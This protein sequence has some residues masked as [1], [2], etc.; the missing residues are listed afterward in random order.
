MK[1][2]FDNLLKILRERCMSEMSIQGSNTILI[3]LSLKNRKKI[4]GKIKSTWELQKLKCMSHQN[5]FYQMPV[6][7]ACVPLKSHEIIEY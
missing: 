7:K 2:N 5:Y 3:K 4:E 1:N 6:T